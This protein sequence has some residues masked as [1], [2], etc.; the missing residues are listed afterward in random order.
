MSVAG[1]FKCVRAWGVQSQGAEAL[2]RD[3]AALSARHLGFGLQPET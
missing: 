1:G 3:V 2:V